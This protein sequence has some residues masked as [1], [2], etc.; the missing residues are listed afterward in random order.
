MMSKILKFEDIGI[1]SA[2]NHKGCCILITTRDMN[3]CRLM[4]CQGSIIKLDI[5][6]ENEARIFFQKHSGI[7]DNSPK[8]L[9]DIAEKIAKK[10]KG[11]PVA[12]AA[13]ASTLKGQ[14]LEDWK[15]AL[16]SL[17][18]PRPVDITDHELKEVYQRLKVNDWRRAIIELPRSIDLLEG[19]PTLRLENSKF[20]DIYVLIKL[21]KLKTLELIKCFINEF[22]HG[23]TELNKL[24]LLKLKNCE[25]NRNPLGVIGKLSK[26]EELYFVGN[27]GSSWE[28]SGE[29]VAGLFDEDNISQKLQRY[30]L[31][32]E[33]ATNVLR[34]FNMADSVSKGVGVEQFFMESISNATIKRMIQKAERLCLRN[35]QRG[36]KSFFPNLVEARGDMN[37]LT[38]LQ[39]ASYSGMDCLVD[40][41]GLPSLTK[42]IFSKLIILQLERIKDMKQLC[43]GHQIP[44]N[45]FEKL[46]W[47]F[48]RD[49]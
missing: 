27:F 39:I 45:L 29:L 17:K 2:H 13:L 40:T 28:F 3:V 49:C 8:K 37:G 22:S 1:P 23:I 26:I 21:Q 41:A 34:C 46:Q 14:N 35:I 44:P 20:E 7:N 10:C 9:K 4:G 47:L 43:Q 38:E 18:N 19:I 24:R 16:R 36:Y 6:L 30:R 25:I 42:T 32:L 12:L 31:S 48:I 11:L 15:A 33:N 5:L